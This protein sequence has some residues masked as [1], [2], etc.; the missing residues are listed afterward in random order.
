MLRSKFRGNRKVHHLFLAQ[1]VSFF[2]KARIAAALDA[3]PKN[4]KVII[5]CSTSKSIAYD[6]A[7][8][9][10]NYKSLAATKNIEVETINF[11]YPPTASN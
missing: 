2:D 10:Q 5:D 7:E 11:R 3:I 4:S 1:V 6:V 9:I 8:L